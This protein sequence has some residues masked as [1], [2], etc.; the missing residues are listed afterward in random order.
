LIVVLDTNVWISALQFGKQYGTP[1]QALEKAMREDIIATADELEEEVFRVLTEKFAWATQKTVS[2]IQSVLAR[3]SRHTLRHAANICR[4]PKD[5]MFLECA[6]LAKAD[7]LVAGDKDLLI[8]GSYEGTRII[9]PLEYIHL[10][11]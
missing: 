5:D 7:Y 3:S 1:V 9:T 6:A 11:R 10:E 4:D 8:L 2:A